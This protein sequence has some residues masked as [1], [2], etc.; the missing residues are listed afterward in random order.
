VQ[1]LWFNISHEAHATLAI[2]MNRIGGKA[3]VVKVVK[4]KFVLR[5][6]KMVIGNVLRSS[7]L[8]P[9]DLA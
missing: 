2:A 9:A 8:L 5:K 6:K 4:M 7:K 1:C 3:I